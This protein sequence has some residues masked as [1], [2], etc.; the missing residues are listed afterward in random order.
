[1]KMIHLAQYNTDST[2]GRGHEVV[3]AA[4]TNHDAAQKAARTRTVWGQPSPVIIMEL[5]DTFEEYLALKKEQTRRQAI[6]RLT[7]EELE[8]LGVNP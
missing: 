5:C 1:M 7:P 8:A 3:F 4:F 6:A 2:E